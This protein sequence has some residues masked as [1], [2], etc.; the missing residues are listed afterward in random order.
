MAPALSEAL[1]L[2]RNEFGLIPVLL[3]FLLAAGLYIW[4]LRGVIHVL[5]ERLDLSAER[6]SFSDER[7][8]S[9]EYELEYWLKKFGPLKPEFPRLLDN[10]P[11]ADRTILLVDDERSIHIYKPALEEVLWRTDICVVNDG[12]EAL[13][14]IARLR[15]VLI[16]TDVV[17]PRMNG[18]QLLTELDC[19]YSEIPVLIV[20]GY[21]DSL[22]EIKKKV[23]MRNLHLE[24]LS[25]PFRRRDLLNA[26]HRLTNERLRP[27][28]PPRATAA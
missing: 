7:R 13:D 11:N 9:A 1:K 14:Q 3:A 19:H 27:K 5:R 28:R 15:P 2:I 20:S 26:I 4:R 21:V 6:K 17:M 10:S 25:K 24:F 23:D 12:A 22:Q 16:I 18:Y 8:T